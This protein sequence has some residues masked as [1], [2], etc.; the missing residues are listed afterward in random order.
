MASPIVDRQTIY[1][2]YSEEATNRRYNKALKK[3]LPFI[4][5]ELA[6][7]GIDD[8]S[9]LRISNMAVFPH[10]HH[11]GNKAD[12]KA[13]IGLGDGLKA[14][15][16][17]DFDQDSFLYDESKWPEYRIKDSDYSQFP[18]FAQPLWSPD[19]G[20]P[21]MYDTPI[22]QGEMPETT[23]QG[24][25]QNENHL[26]NPATSPSEHV[27]F[28]VKD[29]SPRK[30]ALNKILSHGKKF[31]QTNASA[32]SKLNDMQVNKKLQK[33]LTSPGTVENDVNLSNAQGGNSGEH[34]DI[35]QKKLS[36]KMDDMKVTN[37]VNASRLVEYK[38]NFKAPGETNVNLIQSGAPVSNAATTGNHSSMHGKLL[39]QSG[40]EAKGTSFLLN[41]NNSNQANEAPVSQSE[42]NLGVAESKQHTVTANTN[43]AMNIKEAI[44]E[45][46]KAQVQSAVGK[47]SKEAQNQMVL[48]NK[49]QANVDQQEISPVSLLGKKP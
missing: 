29:K 28:K 36:G 23:N 45:A 18:T 13:L 21:D 35:N 1:Y 24:Q 2:C 22:Y 7:Q 15:Y 4:L 5:A 14:S 6:S 19:Q 43:P 33:N 26:N 42:N 12:N 16:A 3:F 47:D 38:P 49:G 31:V 44:K 46:V 40:T 48:S 8:D 10:R 32:S 39:G 25:E 37:K 9:A 20:G 27:G 34:I 11:H 41:N 17:K 30:V